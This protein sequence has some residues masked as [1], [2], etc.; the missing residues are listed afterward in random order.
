MICVHDYPPN[1][2]KI[3]QVFPAARKTG[4][5]FAYGDVVFTPSGE[6]LPPE[7]IVHEEV[8]CKRQLQYPGGVEAWWDRYLTDASF[9][10]IEELLAHR[11]EYRVLIQR[12]VNRNDRRACLNHVAKR[13][14]S[15]LYGR[16]VTL[17]KAKKDITDEFVPG[18]N[19]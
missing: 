14:S 5:I 3:L 11:A 7:L 19:S 17:D 8:H 18:H 16:V 9:R 10:Y 15:P 2:E 6:E 1:I 13:L 12:A 4:V